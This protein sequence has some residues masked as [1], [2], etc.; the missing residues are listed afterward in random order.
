MKTK[1]CPC[2]IFYNNKHS[3]SLSLS[4]YHSPCLQQLFAYS[5]AFDRQM[6][7]VLQLHLWYKWFPG[8]ASLLKRSLEMHKGKD[9]RTTPKDCCGDI[10]PLSWPPFFAP[11]ITIEFS[12]HRPPCGHA[13]TQPLSLNPRSN[14][15]CFDINAT[16]C[17]LC[18]FS[19]YSVVFFLGLVLV[20]SCTTSCSQFL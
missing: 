7:A 17:Y 2:R 9:S 3:L 16:L 1:N 13:E 5:L 18:I 19:L 6:L 15:F 11:L 8:R 20:L 10:V 14:N 4:L 12:L